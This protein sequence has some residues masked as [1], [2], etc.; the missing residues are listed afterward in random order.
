MCVCVDVGAC[1]GIRS[2]ILI[3]CCHV[4][5]VDVGTIVGARACVCGRGRLRV[6]VQWR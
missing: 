5:E 2:R 6:C 4:V 1:V 3:V